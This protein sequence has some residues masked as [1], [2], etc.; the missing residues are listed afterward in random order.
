VYRESKI[1]VTPIRPCFEGEGGDPPALDL[2]DPKVKAAFETFATER[3]A[4]LRTNRDAILEEKRGI[5]TQLDTLKKTWEGLDA[6]AIRGLMKQFE[7]D[8]DAKL[9]SEGKVNDVI[10]RRTERLRLQAQKDVELAQARST[11]LEGELAK[12]GET[13]K[14]LVVDA[15]IRQ[16]ASKIEGFVPG[17]IEDAITRG[18][19]VF[20]VDGE[21]NP[22]A[23]DKD[24]SVVRG[25]DGKTPLQPEEWLRGLIGGDCR[26]WLG[27]S[28]GGGAL[29][30]GE[31]KDGLAKEAVDKMSP[32]AKLEAGLKKAAS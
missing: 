22:V 32:Q 25:S 2:N 12:S 21:R 4:G 23:L 6:E 17:A 15:N 27:T 18:R 5:Q 26:H 11:E 20:S 24:G 28:N 13:I 16:A 8:E 1:Y 29:G 10:E 31:G 7:N 30:G 9:I 14:T 3:E 19:M